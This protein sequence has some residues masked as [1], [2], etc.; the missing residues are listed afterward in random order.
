MTIL[1][2]TIL[3][4]MAV[5]LRSKTGLS[6][7]RYLGF[8]PASIGAVL[9]AGGFDAVGAKDVV[10]NMAIYRRVLLFSAIGFL[11]SLAGLIATRW[12]GD[13]PLKMAT[14]LVGAASAVMCAADI[15]TPY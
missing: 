12:C 5:M 15:V 13:R 3:A 10:S 11:A 1:V 8:V 6:A 14:M 4:L 7:H 2:A 9:W